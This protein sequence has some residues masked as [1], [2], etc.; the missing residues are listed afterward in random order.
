MFM[1]FKLEWNEYFEGIIGR[2]FHGSVLRNPK[3]IRRGPIVLQLKILPFIWWSKFGMNTIDTSK[4]LWISNS[5]RFYW[6][7]LRNPKKTK[8]IILSTILEPLICTWF[9]G[10]RPYDYQNITWIRRT[11]RG[12][13]KLPFPAD[14]T[15]SIFTNPKRKHTF[16]IYIIF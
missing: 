16:L 13:S 4:R 8:F 6:S 15:S 1:I 14:S 11:H 10:F 9:S 3:T 12:K 2:D 5:S 7:F